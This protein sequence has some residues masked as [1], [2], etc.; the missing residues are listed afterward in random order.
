M[1]GEEQ[2]IIDKHFLVEVLKIYHTRET[3]V[4]QVEMLNVGVA[5]VNI[6]NRFPDTYNTNERWVVMKM[7]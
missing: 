2:K 1:L 6:A 5:L 7:R 3:K 4:D